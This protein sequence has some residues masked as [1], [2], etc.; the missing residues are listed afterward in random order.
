MK[1]KW[2]KEEDPETFSRFS[3]YL[4]TSDY[5]EPE[6]ET[7]SSWTPHWKDGSSTALTGL[8]SAPSQRYGNGSHTGETVGEWDAFINKK[9]PSPK[10][11]ITRHSSQVHENYRPVFLGHAN[12]Y[13]F[14]LKY[15]TD[16]LGDLSLKKL[17]A[18]L[19][20][21]QLYPERISDIAKLLKFVH[22]ARRYSHD[23]L[24]KLVMEY[25]ACK[26]E[27]LVDDPAMKGLAVEA[28]TP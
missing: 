28:P 16:G 22:E 25:A 11:L 19:C 7:D 4:Y 12:V 24:R 1:H 18:A 13:V 5:A 27:D 20:E 8:T 9:F 21:F 15:D 17:H 2:L 10:P 14:A 6:P 26:I 3:Q 23:G